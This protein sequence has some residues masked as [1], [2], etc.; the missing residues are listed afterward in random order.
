MTA[1]LS[2]VALAANDRYVHVS[3]GL[4]QAIRLPGGC[5]SVKVRLVG[6]TWTGFAVPRGGTAGSPFVIVSG[7]DEADVFAIALRWADSARTLGMRMDRIV[8]A[9]HGDATGEQHVDVDVLVVAA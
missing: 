4:V 3:P 9:G 5:W 2:S 7:P 1:V 6:D 8:F